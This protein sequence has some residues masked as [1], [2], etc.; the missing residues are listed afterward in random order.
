MSGYK[1]NRLS[2]DIKRELSMCIRELKDPRVKDCMLSIVRTE[3]SGDGSYCK[4]FI[5]AM[6]GIDRAKTAVEGL[7]SASGYLRRQITDALHIRRCPEL[8]FIPD[9]SIAYSA[10]IQQMLGELE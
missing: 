10:K 6:E 7:R 1:V 4:V 9:D 2:E 5:S 8:Q 3:V